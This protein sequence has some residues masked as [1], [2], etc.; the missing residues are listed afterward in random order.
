MATTADTFSSGNITT[1]T[2]CTVAH[3]VAA[4]ANAVFYGFGA[5][6][7]G[8]GH[9]DTGYTLTA[10]YNAVS[11]TSLGKVHSNNSNTG[12]VELFWWPIGTGDGTAHNLVITSATTM[13]GGLDVL[14]AH[15]AS[16]YGASQTQP[17][18]TTGF[19]SASPSRS[20][21]SATGD[22]I[23][24]CFGSGASIAGATQT[25]RTVQNVNAF[26]SD[27]NSETQTAAGAAS[28]TAAYTDNADFWAVIAVNVAQATAAGATAT[29]GVITVI[30]DI[31][32]AAGVNLGGPVVLRG[33]I[34]SGVRLA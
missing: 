24:W 21:T 17:T 34:T 31:P 12:F 22:V 29:P 2:A 9:V 6:G 3:T 13:T 4:Q 33:P 26:S 30:G 7:T 10:T 28:V 23:F 19:G 25:Q 1:G 8:G 15:G 14:M 27:G 16:F 5:V 11:G 32:Q 18:P 20:V